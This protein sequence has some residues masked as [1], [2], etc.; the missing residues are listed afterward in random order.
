MG[1]SLKGKEL[2]V[3]ISQRKDGLYTARFT[4]RLRKRRQKYFKKL[5]ECRNWLAD[6][7]FQDEHGGIDAIGDMTV[8]AWFEYWIE[9]IK[10][11][12]AKHNTVRNYKERYRYNIEP[13]IGKMLLQDV[14]PLHCQN[15]LNQMSMGVYKD[16]TINLAKITMNVLF[17]DAV[18]NGLITRNPVTKSVKITDKEASEP[19]KSMTLDEQRLFLKTAKDSSY[20]NQ[21]AFILQTGLRTGELTALKWSDVDFENRMLHIRRTM[22]YR[23]KE[24]KISTTKTKTGK[25]D[26]PLT[27]TAVEILLDSKN[28]NRKSNIIPIEYHDFVF[29]SR[30]GNPILNSAYNMILRRICKKAGIE[31]YS[32]H[33]LR[34]TFATR[35]IE[36]GMTPKTLQE[37]LGHA[38]ISTT[39]DIYV[40]VTKDSKSNEVKSV[41]SMLNVV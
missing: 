38:N 24:W 17:G 19:K 34:H 32:M 35:C 16:S 10:S 31:K 8:D 22:D 11:G 2:G 1:K 26:I 37:I 23:D 20:F 27:K 15:V 21:Y 40:H 30:N 18:D 13:C 25:R 12:N 3:G 29:L 33:E 36:G 41:E 5:Q 7:Q 6:M 28:S 14:K 4:D 9:N 39:M